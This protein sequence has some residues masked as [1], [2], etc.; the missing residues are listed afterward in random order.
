MCCCSW[1][2]LTSGSRHVLELLQYEANPVFVVQLADDMP[3]GQ[4]VAAIL[5][6]LGNSQGDRQDP[7]VLIGAVVFIGLAEDRVRLERPRGNF[8]AGDD[9]VSGPEEE[10]RFTL[11][12]LVQGRSRPGPPDNGPMRQLRSSRACPG[13]RLRLWL[14]SRPC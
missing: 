9:P 7:K 10:D 6:N 8:P 3:A 5:S 14:P 13:K 4:V 11:A 2:D 1:C 12:G